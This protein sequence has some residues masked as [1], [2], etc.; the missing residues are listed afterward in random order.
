VLSRVAHEPAPADHRASLQAT[1][2][3]LSDPGGD[4]LEI[5]LVNNMPDS[6]VTTTQTQFLRLVRVAV[7]D[8]AFRFRCY[9]L[10]GVPRSEEMRRHLF[11]TYEDIDLLFSRGA[12]AL[13][14]TGAEPRAALLA[15]EPYWADLARLVDWARDHTSSSLWSCLSAHA[16]VQRLDGIVRRRAG[17]KFSGVYSFERGL[18]D[19]LMRGAGQAVLTPHSRYNGLA[20][21]ELERHGYHISSW[22]DSVGVDIF[23]RREPSIFVFLQGHPE[24]DA[25]TLAREYR[26]DV[27][28]FF[29]GER[30]AYPRVPENYFTARTQARLEDMKARASTQ[31]RREC[32]QALDEILSDEDLELRWASDAMR[33]YRNW[34]ALVAQEKSRKN[35]SSGIAAGALDHR[36]AAW[37][38][39]E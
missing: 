33:L 5:A 21:F 31:G 10:P 18:G 9:M 7:G 12:D 35:E 3:P 23:W 39:S 37:R 19:W 22:S 6:A 20:R 15:D 30:D 4:A 13:I 38:R 16:A 25:E 24:Y 11:Q 36:K 32:E 17:E 28:H 29:G 26:R 8:L 2:V 27:I 34:L 1:G 14:V